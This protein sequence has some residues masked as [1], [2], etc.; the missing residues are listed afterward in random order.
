M[1]RPF[2]GAQGETGAAGVELAGKI[3]RLAL[4]NDRDGFAKAMPDD[5]G[6]GVGFRW[7]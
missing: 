3:L 6:G 5:V 4:A 1:N 7:N 2:L